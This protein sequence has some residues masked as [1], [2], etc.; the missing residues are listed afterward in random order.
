MAFV[1][2]FFAALAGSM[3]GGVVADTVTHQYRLRV[4]RHKLNKLRGRRG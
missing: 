2:C 3:V 1:T 4:A